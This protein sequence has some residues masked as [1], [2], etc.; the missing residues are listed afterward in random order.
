M[1][2]ISLL[3]V[4]IKKLSN[5]ELYSANWR[6]DITSALSSAIY[7]I[8]VALCKAKKSKLNEE[9]LVICDLPFDKRH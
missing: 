7:L 6:Q 1:N 2:G 5:A 4:R 9:D 3:A 8:H